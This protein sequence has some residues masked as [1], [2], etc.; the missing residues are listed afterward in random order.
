VYGIFGLY[1]F[2]VKN[3]VWTRFSNYGSL[4]KD[5]LFRHRLDHCS[6]I[7]KDKLYIYGG[8]EMRTPVKKD[9]KTYL[10]NEKLLHYDC[11]KN[12]NTFARKP[13]KFDWKICKSILVYDLIK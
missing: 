6:A 2:D 13:C 3:A 11:M 12:F 4:E 5:L 1:F 8:Y 9:K 7:I 10:Y